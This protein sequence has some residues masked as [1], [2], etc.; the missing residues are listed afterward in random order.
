MLTVRDT[1]QKESVKD[2]MANYGF[3]QIMPSRLCYLQI[4]KRKLHK[5]DLIC[6]KNNITP[7]LTKLLNILPL[8]PHILPQLRNKVVL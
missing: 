2:E 7:N 1:Q 4:Q 5:T 3:Q 8:S 6:K